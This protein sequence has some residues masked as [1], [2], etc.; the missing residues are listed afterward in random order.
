M[1]TNAAINADI[2][3]VSN[4]ISNSKGIVYNGEKCLINRCYSP[5]LTVVQ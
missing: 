4:W 5:L 1:N 2:I 3:I